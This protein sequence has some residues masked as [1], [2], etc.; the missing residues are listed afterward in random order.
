MHAA[1]RPLHLAE[2]VRVTPALH[3]DM[4]V[5]GHPEL[6]RTIVVPRDAP[7]YWVAEAYR[8]SLGIEPDWPDAGVADEPHPLIRLAPSLPAQRIAV[9]GV[10]DAVDVS[11]RGP[12]D[13]QMGDPRVAV[14]PDAGGVPIERTAA[15][16]DPAGWQVRKPAFH[17]ERVAFELARR[18][19]LVQAHLDP[20]T[21]EYGW[22]GGAAS[23][24]ARLCQLLRPARRLA[25]LAHLDETGVLDAPPADAALVAEA[26][27]GIRTIVARMGADGS[28]PDSSEGWLPRAVVAEVVAELGWPD[29]APP[30]LPDP[31]EAL[32][33]FAR[34]TRTIRRLRGRVVVTRLGQALAAGDIRAFRRVVEV[35][36]GIGTARPLGSASPCDVTLALLALADGTAHT[37]DELPDVVALGQGAIA[38]GGDRGGGFSRATRR[39]PG[40]CEAADPPAIRRVTEYF[41]ALSSPG[42]F[43]VIS[44]AMRVVAA[45]AL[46]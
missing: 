16:P 46:R 38:S 23:P 28:P 5:K 7:S 41:S 36:R 12:I 44:P 9:P 4:S 2:H 15:D 21:S 25:L 33:V 8:L 17:A 34:R 1:P 13:P 29:A 27:A 42:A 19:G 35:M 18:F 40:Q 24:I 14:L 31:A 37:F 10:S 20:S 22:T 26:T 11:I 43:G 39:P 30:G 45:E 32:V 6:A 3:V